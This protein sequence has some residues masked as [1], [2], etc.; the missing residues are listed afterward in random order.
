MLNSLRFATPVSEE[1]REQTPTFLRVA[2][3][4]HIS[5]G[6]GENVRHSSREWSIAP[7]L[8]HFSWERRGH[9]IGGVREGGTW[10]IWYPWHPV[11]RATALDQKASSGAPPL[12]PLFSRL[13]SLGLGRLNQSHLG[14]TECRCPS[15]VYSPASSVIK[16][17][18]SGSLGLFIPLG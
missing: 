10:D 1:G 16:L 8:P 9:L 17:V 13:L 2:D 3:G 11:S 7:S 6:G 18:P 4:S 15:M 14:R 12:S 5:T